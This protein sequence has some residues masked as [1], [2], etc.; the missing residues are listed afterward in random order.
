[1]LIYQVFIG[2]IGLNLARMNEA[3]ALPSFEY[4]GIMKPY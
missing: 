3:K 1:M 2:C 4:F